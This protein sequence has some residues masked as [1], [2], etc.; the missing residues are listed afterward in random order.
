VPEGPFHLAN[1]VFHAAAQ[2][3]GESDPQGTPLAAEERERLRLAVV[4]YLE[5]IEAQPHDG[6]ATLV[7]DR[8]GY[9]HGARPGC[10]GGVVSTDSKGVQ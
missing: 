2:V 3:E 1:L 6:F 10:E 4:R 5:I 9:A 7:H 8:D